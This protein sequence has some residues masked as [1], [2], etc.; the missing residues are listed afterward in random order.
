VYTICGH[1]SEFSV[2]KLQCYYLSN[3][4]SALA[5]ILAPYFLTQILFQV[6]G[7]DREGLEK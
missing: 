1:A 7:E 3:T 4:R 2:Y 5:V 6:Q